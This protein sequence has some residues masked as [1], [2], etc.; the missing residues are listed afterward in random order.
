MPG[1]PRSQSLSGSN[2][3]SPDMKKSILAALLL[4]TAWAASGQGGGRAASVIV[5][6]VQTEELVDRHEALA[7]VLANESITLSSTVDDT[8][9]AIHFRE[10]DEVKAGQ[11]L[12]ELTQDEEK[13][14]WE[15]ALAREAEKRSALRRIEELRAQEL[16]S[17]AQLDLA[18]AEMNSAAAE[19]RARR[20]ALDDRIIRAPFAGVLGIREVSPGAYVRAGDAITSLHDLS[21]LK[22]EFSL[23]ESWLA[24]LDD[25]LEL[26]ARRPQSQTRQS[27]VLQARAVQLDPAT[28]S[29]RLR[30][31][32]QASVA[33]V[34]PGGLML[35]ELRS[36]PRQTLTVHEAAL[37]PA[38]DGQRVYLLQEGKA[39]LQEVRIGARRK[40][41]VEIIEGLNAGQ[42]VIVHGANKLRPGSPVQVLGVYD[43]S[44]P[45]A[46]L[47][48]RQGSGE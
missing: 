34:A 31:L 16:A 38:A 9:A 4:S 45:I 19:V 15:A 44:V 27:A 37:L 36:R 11:I 39:V 43:G 46:E 32:L 22:L 29:L 42:Q 20:A 30:A 35:V 48:R 12:V 33:G 7:T 25:G 2:G 3:N 18:R 5:S 13:A 40:G 24:A 23:P 41:R 10:G 6:A 47:L 1:K 21:L 14:A 26:V 28:R 17:A 8:V